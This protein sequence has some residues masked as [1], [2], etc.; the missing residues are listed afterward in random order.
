[1]LS[2]A[3]V[4]S[5]T[6]EQELQLLLLLLLKVKLLIYKF[7]YPTFASSCFPVINNFRNTCRW[8]R[9]AT[10]FPFKCPGIPHLG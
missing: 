3:A 2:T 5:K 9:P 10:L 4:G 7:L 8:V 1:M 6:S